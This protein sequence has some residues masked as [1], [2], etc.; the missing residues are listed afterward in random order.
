MKINKALGALALASVLVLS[1]CGDDSGNNDETSGDA[2]TGSATTEPTDATT[3]TTSDGATE[4]ATD[5][6]SVDVADFI[7]DLKAGMEGVTTAHMSM[8]MSVSGQKFTGEGQIDYTSHPPEMAMTMSMPA[9][10]ETP[11]EMRFVGGFFYMNLGA[12]SGNKFVKFSLDDLAELSGAGG[13]DFTQA[14][15]PNASFEAYEEGVREVTFQGEDELAG[16]HTRH[17]KMVIDTAKVSQFKDLPRSAAAAIPKKMVMD[18][19]LD[20]DNRMTQL[21]MDL[22]GTLSMT[23]K[24]FDW[25]Q[26]VDIVKPKP[27]E[28]TNTPGM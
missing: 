2:A 13:L 25:G 5:G 20:D 3:D 4:G 24:V 23:A 6:E 21:K 19:W 9:L 1:G 26:P 10:S 18:V 27:S 14:M 28:I 7:A 22:P 16:V 8:E 11:V 15:D 17:Y 12:T